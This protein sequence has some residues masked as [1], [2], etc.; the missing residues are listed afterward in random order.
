M[1][2][3]LKQCILSVQ[4]ACT[5]IVAEI[6]VVDNHSSD[7]SVKMLQLD[8]PKVKCIPNNENLGF[9]KAN[10]LG[11]S[12][13]QGEY[14]LILNPDTVIGENDLLKVLNFAK[15]HENFGAIGV[16][17]IDGSGK[18]LPEC[19]RNVPTIKIARQKILGNG[20]NYYANQIKEKLVAPVP[21]LTGAF[22]LMCKSVFE[23]VGGFDEDYFM[24]GEDIDLSFKLLQSG[25]QNYYVGNTTIV[26]YKGESTVRNITYLQHFYGAMHLFYN[27][28]FKVNKL[29]NRLSKL[30][31][32]FLVLINN[33][34]LKSGK[35]KQIQNP[36]I[37]F[38]GKDKDLLEKV[39]IA[40]KAKMVL[41]SLVIPENEN[42]EMVV[43][44]NNTLSYAEIIA[45]LQHQKLKNAVKRIIPKG[46]DFMLESNSSLLHGEVVSF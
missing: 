24:Y 46:C 13:A 25:Y 10:N 12:F 19:K 41:M 31:V 28:H 17:F 42:F 45:L 30:G 35:K 7:E 2:Y 26:H 29:L 15:E 6:I 22:M 1:Q 27:K 16:R 36:K 21:V 3:F 5:D 32:N 14:I 33:L 20:K 44:D 38:L 23:H 11:V 9:S 34:Q 4:Q 39:R 43:F 18:F 37:L 40:T 8:F